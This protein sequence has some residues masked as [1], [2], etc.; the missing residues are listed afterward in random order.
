MSQFYLQVPAILHLPKYLLSERRLVSSPGP[1][2]DGT[3]RHFVHAD[4]RRHRCPDQSLR[5]WLS[6]AETFGELTRS[7]PP[8]SAVLTAESPRLSASAPSIL[9][10]PSAWARN[11]CLSASSN[12]SLH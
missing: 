11:T 7:P 4:R 12:S 1:P 8:P 5:P 2:S 3:P 9:A 6:L 10:P